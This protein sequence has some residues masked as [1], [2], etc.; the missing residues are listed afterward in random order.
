MLASFSVMSVFDYWVRF[1]VEAFSFCGA[2]E[3]FK[4]GFQNTTEQG[5]VNFGIFIVI[6][7]FVSGTSVLCGLKPAKM[8]KWD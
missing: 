8:S 7:C 3:T 2:T 6:L 4:L 1:Y 5:L